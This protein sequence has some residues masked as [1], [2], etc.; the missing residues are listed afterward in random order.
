MKAKLR[1]M[2]FHGSH[3]L[4][5]QLVIATSIDICIDRQKELKGMCASLFPSHF[6]HIA[7]VLCVLSW[8]CIDQSHPHAPPPLLPCMFNSRTISGAPP[9]VA[10]ITAPCVC[11]SCCVMAGR[12]FK[13][14][15]I[16]Y[17]TQTFAH[18]AIEQCSLISC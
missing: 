18:A 4:Q 17:T 15:S 8:Q 1:K 7:I 6:P 16:P 13:N 9:S 12:E 14:T 11:L 3:K 10:D 5:Q 2:G